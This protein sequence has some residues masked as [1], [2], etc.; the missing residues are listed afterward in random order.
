M[1][2]PSWLQ[3]TASFSVVVNVGG[4]RT[5]DEEDAS[6]FTLAVFA[7]MAGDEA[8]EACPFMQDEILLAAWARRIHQHV[9]EAPV[10]RVSGV[11]PGSGK[12][13]AKIISRKEVV[14]LEQRQCR[15]QFLEAEMSEHKSWVDNDVYDLVDMRKTPP[16]HM[17][18]K[19]YGS[20]Q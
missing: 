11:K 17:L 7:D 13:E 8:P 20:S 6:P 4:I 12:P 14:Q 16:N 19:V 18:S 9:K 1:R 2:H 5:L 15:Q 10:Y 3:N